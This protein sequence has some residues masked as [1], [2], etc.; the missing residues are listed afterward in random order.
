MATGGRLTEH[1]EAMAKMRQ[2]ME[3]MKMNQSLRGEENLAR[4]LEERAKRDTWR[5]MSGM[6]LMMHEYNHPGNKPFVIGFV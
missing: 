5:Q 3:S 6:K 4:R 1:Y 2:I